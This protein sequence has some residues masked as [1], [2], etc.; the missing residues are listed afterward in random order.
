MRTNIELDDNLLKE[1]FRFS[2]AKTKRRLVQT[3]LEE[4][5]RNHS[6][7]DLRALKGKIRFSKHYDYKKMRAS[8]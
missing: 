6:R 3:A 5:V 7:K 2:R 8:L 1:A 4:F